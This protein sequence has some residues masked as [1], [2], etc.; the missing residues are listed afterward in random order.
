MTNAQ[1]FRMVIFAAAASFIVVR[2]KKQQQQRR[3]RRKM[4]AIAY[5]YFPQIAK[6]FAVWL[7]SQ[8]IFRMQFIIWA[9]FFLSLSSFALHVS[10]FV[11]HKSSSFTT[12]L[13]RKN[14]GMLNIP[15][16]QKKKTNRTKEEEEKKLTFFNW[17]GC[18]GACDDTT[19]KPWLILKCEVWTKKNQPLTKQRHSLVSPDNWQPSKIST[20]AN[21]WCVCV[22]VKRLFIF[23]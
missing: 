8:C 6:S 10:P 7:C 1:V 16:K 5:I 17:I 11:A 21:V 14:F 19:Q 20:G 23:I 12:T 15:T 22:D 3:R 18:A 13:R 2:R 9:T 4:N